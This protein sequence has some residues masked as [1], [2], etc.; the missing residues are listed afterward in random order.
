MHHAVK[1]ELIMIVVSIFLE[2]LPKLNFLGG[3]SHL[4]CYRWGMHLPQLQL[5]TCSFDHE[6]RG[7]I[8]PSNKKLRMLTCHV[9]AVQ[10]GR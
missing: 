3:A 8:V 5:P 4:L 7:S 6:F 10:Q 2:N 1:F 9:N